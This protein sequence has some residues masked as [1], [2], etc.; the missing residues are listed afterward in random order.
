MKELNIYGPLNKLDISKSSGLNE[1][2]PW[3]LKKPA[4]FIANPRSICFNLFVIQGRLPKDWKNALVTPV[5]KIGTGHKPEN[6]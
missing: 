4:K 2:H 6:Y 1:M 3:L 5:F